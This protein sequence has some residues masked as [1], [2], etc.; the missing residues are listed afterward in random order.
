[1]KSRIIIF[2]AF[3]AFLGLGLWSGCDLADDVT[4]NFD[5]FNTDATVEFP[6]LVAEEGNGKVGA[7]APDCKTTS[8]MAELERAEVD[9][10]DVDIDEVDLTFLEAKYQNATWTPD[11]IEEISCTFTMTG[12]DT[13]VTV[14]ETAVNGGSSSWEEVDVPADAVD[15]INYYLGNLEEEFEYCVDC[16]EVDTDSH[17]VEYLVRMGVE[18]SGEVEK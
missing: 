18:I 3:V 15:M 4:D 9:L 1:M 17:Y 13:T 14:A 5:D 11:T 12:H 10:D 7:A 16:G 8:I 6:P 2:T